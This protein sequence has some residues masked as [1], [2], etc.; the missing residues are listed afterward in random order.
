MRKRKRSTSLNKSSDVESK[1]F[2]ETDDGVG[3]SE[4]EVKDKEEMETTMARTD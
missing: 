2:K 3:K 1:K 4:I